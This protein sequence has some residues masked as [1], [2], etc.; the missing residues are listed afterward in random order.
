MI[1][2]AFSSRKQGGKNTCCEFLQR[3]ATLFWPKIYEVDDAYG[4]NYI[5]SPSVEIL[6]IA[7][8]MKTMAIQLGV[9]KELVWGTDAQKNELTNI[10]WEQLPHYKQIEFD[11]R[12]YNVVQTLKYW[13]KTITLD[14]YTKSTKFPPSGPMTVRQVLQEI[15]ESI[16]LKMNPE[17]FV[18]Q[19][20]DYVRSSSADIGLVADPRKPNQI[21]ALKE[22]GAT[23][24]RL[25]RNPYGNKDTHISETALDRDVYDY[26]NFD[27]VIENDKMTV[28][29]TNECVFHFLQS[30]NIISKDIDKG[31]VV[32]E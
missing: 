17:F 25:T 27:R 7:Y 3:N 21:A 11:I 31:S 6:Y 19:F 2:I 12:E 24:I 22:L 29:E 16:F 4:N 30:K 10:K 9:P 5:E 15:G 20:K 32:W 28:A 18:N 8:P 13:D 14:E 26:N 1:L 23:V